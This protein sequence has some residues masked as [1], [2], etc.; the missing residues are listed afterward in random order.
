MSFKP[1]QYPWE[2]CWV[3]AS[4]TF[5]VEHL[6]PTADGITISSSYEVD[7]CSEHLREELRDRPNVPHI[8]ITQI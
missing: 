4:H 3:E 5:K 2:E 6:Y 8:T 7:V 1:C